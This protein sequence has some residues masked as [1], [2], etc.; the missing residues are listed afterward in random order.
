MAMNTDHKTR[1]IFVWGH[2][3]L[4][5]AALYFAKAMP[6]IRPAV[7]LV[8]L[9]AEVGVVLGLA[10]RPLMTRGMFMFLLFQVLQGGLAFVFAK[11]L[12]G[13][14][15]QESLAYPG[16]A[17]MACIAL[18][19]VRDRP[20]SNFQTLILGAFLAGGLA[21]ALRLG[22]IPGGLAYGLAVLN[23]YYPG[24]KILSGATE[25]QGLWKRALF[26]TA[27]LAVGRAA[28]QYYLVQSNYANLGVVITHPY[29]Y[30]A[31]VSGLVLPFLAVSC[32]REKILSPVLWIPVLGILLPL[33]LGIFFHARP[34]AGFLLGLVTATFIT[35]L[36]YEE[37]IPL[38]LLHNLAIGT[39]VLALPLFRKFSDLSRVVRLEILAGMLVVAVLIYLI[40]Q[41][42]KASRVG[43]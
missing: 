1:L 12:F 6:T 33:A 36:L 23:S 7:I 39:A 14:P 34:M 15:L 38:G 43:A 5:G 35:G 16:G 18:W 10:M 20:V 19:M 8:L 30:I 31:L 25:A 24:N 40:T 32:S 4:L 9:F 26:L 11:F 42:S 41:R 21:L 17:L 28:L 3:L 37:L 22:G 13:L 2:G 27:L 29:T